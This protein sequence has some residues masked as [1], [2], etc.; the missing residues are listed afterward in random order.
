MRDEREANTNDYTRHTRLNYTN[1]FVVLVAHFESPL[2][3]SLAKIE[4][5]AA[6]IRIYIGFYYHKHNVH[7]D[8]NAFVIAFKN[9]FGVSSDF[10]QIHTKRSL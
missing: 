6:N 8:S 1:I 3:F 2:S 5:R 7:E 10:A 9:V 4:I